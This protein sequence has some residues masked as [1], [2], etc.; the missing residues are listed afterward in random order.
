MSSVSVTAICKSTSPNCCQASS[1]GAP[2]PIS[3]LTM[4]RID[5]SMSR[6]VTRLAGSA[7]R[8]PPKTRPTLPPV[9]CSCLPSDVSTKQPTR[10]PQILRRIAIRRVE[11]D[12]CSNSRNLGAHI[13]P[14]KATPRSPQGVGGFERLLQQEL[15][16]LFCG[17]VEAEAVAGPVVELVGDAVEVELAVHGEVGALGK[18]RRSSP[19]VFSLL[20]RCHGA[21][22]SQ[23][24]TSIPVAKGICFDSRISMPWSQVSE[25]R[26]DSG[27]VL[28][29]VAMA[30]T[31]CSVL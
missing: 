24:Y 14:A 5:C 9:A 28:I 22:G 16:E 7:E 20:P 25:R 27:S 15:C 26:S 10:D 17:L 6:L 11:S 23:K 18:Y 1:G 4:E 2:W 19:L 29:L 8:P 31:T 12:L 30:G 21:C 13:L 3:L